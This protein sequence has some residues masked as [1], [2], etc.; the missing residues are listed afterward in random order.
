M[1]AYN[2][3]VR[4]SNRTK[5]FQVTYREAGMIK[6]VQFVGGLPPLRIWEGKNR[7]KIGAILRNFA[8]RSRI[9]PKTDE[10]I[11]KRKSS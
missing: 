3:G 5:L 1:S 11:D 7:P 9:S 4:G 8:L 2:F 10:D 6:W